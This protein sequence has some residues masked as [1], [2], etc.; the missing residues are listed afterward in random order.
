[1]DAT[2]HQLGGILLQAVPT[3]ILVLLLHFYLKA[4]FFKPLEH[5]L[6]T[7][8]QATEGARKV[9][10]ESMARAAAAAEKYETA[11]RAARGE[12][13]QEQDKIHKQLQERATADLKEARLRADVMVQ[14]AQSELQKEVEAAK[15]SL[16]GDSDRLAEE[17]VAAVLRRSA[18]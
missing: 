18:A 14:A 9:A 6:H 17:I 10:Q 4:I 11:L 2:L 13:Y 3:I 12:V 8:Y 5:V 15:A 1:M 7:R 16:A